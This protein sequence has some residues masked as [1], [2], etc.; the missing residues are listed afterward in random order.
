MKTKRT[1]FYSIIAICSILV[2]SVAGYGQGKNIEKTYRWTY[3]ADQHVSLTFNNYDCN[4][5]IHTWDKPD[6]EYAMSVDATLKSEEDAGRLDQFIE[7]LEFSRTSG[8]I[9]FNNHFWTSRVSVAGKKTMTVKGLKT[10]QYTEFNMEGEMWI[11]ENCILHLNSKYSEIEVDNLSGEV[12]LDLYNDKLFGSDVNSDMKIT[13]KYCTLEF[14]KMKNI[15]ANLYNTDIETGDIGNLDIISKYSNLEM[16]NAGRLHIEAYNDKY[17]FGST[18]DIRFTDKYS[19]LNV[20]NA[21]DVEL[22]CYNSTVN[23]SKVRD[24]DL[25][26]KYGKYEMNKINKLNIITA[27]NDN[28]KIEELG[29]LGIN[30]SKYSVFKLDRLEHSLVLK[31][32]YSDKIQIEQTGAL[33]EVNINGKYVDLQMAI[34]KSLNYR[35]NASVKYGKLDIN[36]EAMNVKKK[37]QNG[38]ELE[39]EAIKGRET[40]G[41][42]SFFVNGYDMAVTLTEQ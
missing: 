40:D 33:K 35:F 6:I 28:F 15:E 13:A 11:P 18:G 8:G 36:E 30:E 10:I 5:T 32:G 16:G 7:G 17:S 42:L 21:G 31:D 9:E 41:M 3:N 24:V 29:D 38:S 12:Y 39:M 2:T 37:I 26:S 14:E 23:I 22:N 1:Y 27:Y 34:G 25:M 19:D 4:L 20:L